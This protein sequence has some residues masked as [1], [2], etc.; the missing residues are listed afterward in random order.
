VLVWDAKTRDLKCKIVSDMAITGISFRPDGRR[1][2]VCGNSSRINIYD[3][4]FLVDPLNFKDALIGAGYLHTSGKPWHKIHQAVLSSQNSENGAGGG[5]SEEPGPPTP[6]PRPRI[7]TQKDGE[8]DEDF[9]KRKKEEREKAL[10]FY[11]DNLRRSV[12]S[13]LGGKTKRR[14]NRK[15]K[16]K[17]KTTKRKRT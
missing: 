1:I 13:F 7:I 10:V 3:L 6:Y 16:R 14:K 17:R 4:D 9:E 2:A 12:L 15:V 5:R 8:T 11:N